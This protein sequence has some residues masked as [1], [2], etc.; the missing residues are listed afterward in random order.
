MRTQRILQREK[1]AI[2]TAAL[3]DII[4]IL[5]FFFMV[6]TVLKKE[7][8]LV[9]TQIPSAT[10]AEK[11]AVKDGLIDLYVGPPKQSAWGQEAR[12]Q[13]GD[14]LMSPSEIPLLVEQARSQMSESGAARLVIN[15]K[16]DAKVKMGIISDIKQ[17]LRKVNARRVNYQTIHRLEKK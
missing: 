5:L 16:V 7:Q 17:Q 2:S 3:P 8:P 12:I 14:Y 15:L 13:M 10:Q 11:L 9:K 1:P 6:S 4:F